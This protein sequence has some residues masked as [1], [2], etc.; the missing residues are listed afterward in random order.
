[1]ANGSGTNLNPATFFNLVRKASTISSLPCLTTSGPNKLLCGL[2]AYA[3]CFQ[4]S[5]PQNFVVRSMPS[6]GT[7]FWVFPDRVSVHVHDRKVK[8]HVDGFGLPGLV[9]HLPLNMQSVRVE[10]AQGAF[11]IRKL[12]LRQQFLRRY[13]VESPVCICTSL[14]SPQI[15]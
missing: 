4:D 6:R 12:N 3:A 5:S 11:V 9:H 13:S 14:L 7:F 1:M 15:F 2:S 8:E 10:Q